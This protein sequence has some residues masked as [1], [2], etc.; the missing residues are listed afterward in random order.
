ME[1]PKDDFIQWMIGQ[2]ISPDSPDESHKQ[3]EVMR[4]PVV[5]GR[6]AFEGRQAP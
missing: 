2:D 3:G 6:I 1:A 4:L 5:E